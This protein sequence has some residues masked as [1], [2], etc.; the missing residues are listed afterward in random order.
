MFRCSDILRNTKCFYEFYVRVMVVFEY[1]VDRALECVLG[2]D[3]Y[4]ILFSEST[5]C[6][7]RQDIT[8][9][10]NNCGV[11]ATCWFWSFS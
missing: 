4:N 3:N 5:D 1:L 7:C 10:L 2:F 6:F 8:V 9:I 11:N